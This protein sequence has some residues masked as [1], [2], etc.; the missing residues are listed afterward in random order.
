MY[1]KLKF[2]RGGIFSTDKPYRHITRTISSCEL[3]IVTEGEVRMEIESERISATSGTVLCILPGEMHGGYD[4][5]S[6][7]TFFWLH[8][9]GADSCELPPRVCRPTSF[10]RT[11]LLSKEVLHYS[12]ADSYPEGITECIF[13]ALLAEICHK[14]EEPGSL[15][16]SVK[17]YIRRNRMRGVSVSELAE[18]F[19]YNPDYLN[20]HFKAK[21]GIGLKQYIS[22]MRLDGIKQELLIG[23]GSLSEIALRC[24]FNDYKYFL[25][26]FKYHQGISPSEYKETYYEAITN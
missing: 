11:V 14:G 16:A 19:G 24:G 5:S 8:F 18:K 25:K 3:I 22:N 12:L 15:V 9:D 26:F 23:E 6:G 20:R 2:I 4:Y 7:A 21:C 1:G 10:E 17:E 13:R